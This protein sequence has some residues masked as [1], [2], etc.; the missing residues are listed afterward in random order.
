MQI[1]EPIKESRRL[2]GT[3]YTRIAG[4]SI[5]K[6]QATIH[7]KTNA[8]NQLISVVCIRS[9]FREMP[10]IAVANRNPYRI[11]TI[12]FSGSEGNVSPSER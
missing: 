6:F 10:Y 3:A 11:Q 8:I 4:G 2:S 9:N 1:S 7:I 5:S 12:P